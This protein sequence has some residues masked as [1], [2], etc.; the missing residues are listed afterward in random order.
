MLTV[1]PVRTSIMV[2]LISAAP[3]SLGGSYSCHTRVLARL[4]PFS[5]VLNAGTSDEGMSRSDQSDILARPFFRS[6]MAMFPFGCK[7][8]PTPQAPDL[9]VPCNTMSSSRCRMRSSAKVRAS[10]ANSSDSTS[11]LP[12]RGLFTPPSN[13]V[14]L[15]YCRSPMAGSVTWTRKRLPS[16]M[17]SMTHL[18]FPPTLLQRSTSDCVSK[19]SPAFFMF[20][21]RGVREWIPAWDRFASS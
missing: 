1:S 20:L 13:S 3:E 12:T 8:E 14:K 18:I 9:S 16:K 21:T 17:Y 5:A 7:I 4:A 10:S 2:P 11:A 6:S 15:A 19:A